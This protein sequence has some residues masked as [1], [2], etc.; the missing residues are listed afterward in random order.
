MNRRMQLIKEQSAKAG[1]LA[2]QLIASGEMGSGIPLNSDSFTALQSEDTT[3]SGSS[4]VQ[5]PLITEQT[6]VKE[7]TANETNTEVASVVSES[8]YKA[9][10]K[11]MNTAQKER[12]ETE[13]M[14]KD[15][16][17]QNRLINDELQKI[18]ETQNTKLELGTIDNSD[19][20]SE[21]ENEYPKTVKIAEKKAAQIKKELKGEF[22]TLQDELTAL[23]TEI[24]EGKIAKQMSERDSEIK[25]VHPDFDEVRLSDEFKNWIYSSAPTMYKG[26]YEGTIPFDISDVIK[27]VHDYKNSMNLPVNT[28]NLTKKTVSPAE[29]SV[30]TSPS[31]S[32]NMDLVKIDEFTE[33][34]FMRLSTNIHKIK[35]PNKRAELMK[36][37]DS[38]FQKQFTKN[39]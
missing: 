26:V 2:Q 32:S 24:E 5:S 12:A 30:R 36:R 14:L 29:V 11:A 7:K 18:K 31:V 3:V 16:A 38:F 37:A 22:K 1:E 23:K 9:A 13:K 35:D 34:D 19:D 8:Q 33:Q 20:V 25:K 39:N 6:E 27:V 10:V 21:W 4:D 17:E 28:K 15:I